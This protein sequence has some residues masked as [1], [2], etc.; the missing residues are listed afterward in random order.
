MANGRKPGRPPLFPQ[1]ST[2]ISM[3]V[4]NGLYDW[5]C[6]AARRLGLDVASA[7]RRYLHF[8]KEL[9]VAAHDLTLEWNLR[10]TSAIYPPIIVKNQGARIAAALP[11]T[12]ILGGRRVAVTFDPSGYGDYLQTSIIALIDGKWMCMINPLCHEADVQELL[13]RAN[14]PD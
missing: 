14:E 11:Q 3:R 9:A 12:I 6:G 7:Y 8:E 10:C 13:R 4:S 5:L 1:G 2:V